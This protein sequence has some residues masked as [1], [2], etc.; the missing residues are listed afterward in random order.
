[1]VFY[2]S[3]NLLLLLEQQG[4]PDPANLYAFQQAGGST[5]K[6]PLLLDNNTYLIFAQNL[7]CLFFLFAASFAQ[8]DV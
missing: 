4:Y 1:V 2:F 6:L 3:S 5:L 7:I 8:V